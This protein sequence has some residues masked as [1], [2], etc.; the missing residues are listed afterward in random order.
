MKKTLTALLGLLLTTSLFANSDRALAFFANE[1][2]P[3]SITLE[4]TIG[5]S[6]VY[7]R[8]DFKLS[9]Q[10]PIQMEKEIYDKICED[11]ALKQLANTNILTYIYNYS[12]G[13]LVIQMDGC[14]K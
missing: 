7:N 14:S 12:D 2:D 8:K 9:E 10:K 13:V 5:Y 6:F 4:T 3:A 1:K 11:P